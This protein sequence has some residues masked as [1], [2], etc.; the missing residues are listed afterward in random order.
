MR[1]AAP[2]RSGTQLSG[3]GSTARHRRATPRADR[4]GGC[5]GDEH[6]RDRRTP[7]RRRR[8]LAS[9]T[10][11]ADQ[12]IAVTRQP[13]C[14]ET[15]V[16]CS[17]A[18]AEIEH[19]RTGRCHV[20]PGD[21]ASR[22][23]MSHNVRLHAFERSYVG[24]TRS[25][26]PLVWSSASSGHAHGA[27]LHPAF[28]EHTHRWQTGLL[29][30]VSDW[31]NTGRFRLTIVSSGSSRTLPIGS[32]KKHGRTRA[33]GLDDGRDPR[34]VAADGRKGPVAAAPRRSSCGS[35]RSLSGDSATKPGVEVGAMRDN[36][37]LD[38][39]L[40]PGDVV[41][42]EAEER[43]IGAAPC[44]RT[45]ATRHPRARNEMPSRPSA[46][47][48]SIS[49]AQLAVSWR[50]AASRAAVIGIS[51]AVDRSRATPAFHGLSAAMPRTC[52]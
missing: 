45:R 44:G 25:K 42:T 51:G 22:S 16:V 37:P 32:W 34:R 24:A 52:S 20:V 36:G 48:R 47:A 28:N 17:G 3:P 26:A 14:A 39:L 8:S 30:T 2:R 1:R 10:I 9:R 40:E 21:G 13:R 31:R 38:I 43:R 12:S 11:A 18:A 4:A 5:R 29:P 49:G 46:F 33:V 27:F 41:T 23:R 35:L 50:D 7:A 19:V 6:R 15:L